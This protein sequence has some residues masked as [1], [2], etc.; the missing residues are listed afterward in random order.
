MKAS[1][2]IEVLKNLMDAVGD[3]EVLCQAAGCC[4]HGHE[5]YA[6]EILDG[7]IVVRV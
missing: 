7:N 2:L 5:I 6:I 1:E 3:A 4:Y